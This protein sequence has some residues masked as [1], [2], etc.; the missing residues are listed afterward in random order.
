MKPTPKQMQEVFKNYETVV[1]H[2]I[3]EG[4]ADDKESADDIIKG[5]SEQW[6]NLIISD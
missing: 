4:Y 6:Y 2:L 3:S 5:M 1:D